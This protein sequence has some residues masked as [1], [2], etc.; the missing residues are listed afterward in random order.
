M[1][2]FLLV[3]VSVLLLVVFAV[4][5]LFVSQAHGQDDSTAV[6]PAALFRN[7]TMAEAYKPIGQHNPI[8]PHRFGADPYALVYKDR[9]YVY[10]TNDAIIRDGRGKVINNMYGLI[11][12]I[13]CASSADLVNWTDHGLIEI[14]PPLKGIAT[15][16]GNS[17]APAAIYSGAASDDS[18]SSVSQL[19]ILRLLRAVG[20]RRLQ[21][22][23][24]LLALPS[25]RA[26]WHR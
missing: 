19:P 2:P 4:G 12:S 16:A 21:P 15:W 6:D 11:R 20:G 14:G 7:V 3:R 25:D 26:D 9:V 17:W 13:S 1:K 5:C 24:D 10:T 22:D 18:H 23:R 8:L